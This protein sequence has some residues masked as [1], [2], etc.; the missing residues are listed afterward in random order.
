M[1]CS[2]IIATCNRAASLAKTLRALGEVSLPPGWS[3]ELIVVDNASTDNTAGVAQSAGLR[4][5]TIRYLYEG[6]VGKSNALNTG[7]AS[8]S[9]EILLFTDDDVIP[10]G[11]WLERLAR[12]LLERDCD[13][14]AGHIELAEHLRRP[15]MRPEHRHWL[16][17]PDARLNG[18][19]EFIGANMGFHRG[20]L[21]RVPAFDPELGP[22]AVGL[23]EE[24]L[25]A[26]QMQEAGF[27]L[28]F[29][30]EASVVHAPDPSRLRRSQWLATARKHGGSAAYI[31]HH[32][33]HDKVKGPRLRW[34]CLGAKLLLRRLFQPPPQ[35]QGEGCPPWEMSYVAEMERC[36]RFL[37]ERLRPR[38]Y[39][40]HGLRKRSWEDLNGQPEAQ[41]VVNAG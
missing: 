33:Q 21:Q 3:A 30:A 6:R 22:G 5:F 29:I 39:L 17:A 34:C 31:L 26:L 37:I 16:A 8:A 32:W 40:K 28:R 14:A 27:R 19:P 24:L 12:P 4:N 18:E 20:V 23:G 38:N 7:L 9:G 10:A 36:R 15:W 1:E 13:A 2:V 41:S 35:F 11:D 25:F